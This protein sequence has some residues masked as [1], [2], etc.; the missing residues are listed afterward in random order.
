MAGVQSTDIS[1]S[2]E[3]LMTASTYFGFSLREAAATA[4]PAT[5][6]IHHGT[7]NTAEL[8]DT[9]EL[10]ANESAREF[11]PG[12]IDARNGIY[13]DIVAGTVEGAVRWQ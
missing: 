7:D 9:V 10:A 6:N 13:V 4:A 1:G 11:Y 5:V 2:D 12:G 3:Q 8:L